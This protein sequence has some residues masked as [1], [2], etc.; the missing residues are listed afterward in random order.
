MAKLAGVPR[1]VTKRASVILEHLNEGSAVP[2][3]KI[4]PKAKIAENP[5]GA[6]SFDDLA[7]NDVIEKLEK[8][9]PNTLTPIEALT[10]LFELK[11]LLTE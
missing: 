3:G 2:E 8:L 6:V 4:A 1:E 11:N 5:S 10:K 9:D 7:R